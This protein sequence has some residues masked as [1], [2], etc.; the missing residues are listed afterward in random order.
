MRA[1]E[2][3]EEIEGERAVDKGALFS[4]RRDGT[5]GVHAGPATQTWG[6]TSPGR[7]SVRACRRTRRHG[8]WPIIVGC[9]GA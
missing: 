6:A 7:V 2:K 8:S 9:L 1:G 4:P 3:N 5:D